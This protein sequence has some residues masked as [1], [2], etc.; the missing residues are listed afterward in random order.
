MDTS[1]SKMAFVT[2][3]GSTISE[4]FGRARYFE[5][6]TVENGRITHRER[7]EKGG[8]HTFT[9][10]HG[11]GHHHDHDHKHQLMMEPILDCSVLIARGMGN[12]AHQHLTTMGIRPV[13]TDVRTIE[14]AAVAY[15]AGT[16]AENPGRL[17]DHGH[18]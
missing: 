9:G 16:L 12:G 14:E 17:H 5:V 11:G 4:H 7:R 6:L 8:H 2:D 10:E 3:D 15:I 18:G 13:L 1:H